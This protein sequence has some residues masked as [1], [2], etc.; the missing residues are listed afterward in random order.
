[1][2][3]NDA[4]L[5]SN[6]D[7]FR[8]DS[9]ANYHGLL[10][11]V[12]GSI[13]GVNLSANHTWAHCISDRV[14]VGIANPNQT[15]HRDRDRANCQSDRRHIFNLTSVA[16]APRFE[17]PTWRA[18]ASDWRLSVLYRVSSGTP[19][20]ITAGTD[21]ALT[22]LAGQ[23]ADQVSAD[24]YQDTSGRLGSQFLNRAAFAI[25]ALGTYGNLDRFTVRGFATWTLD[26]AL[27]RIFNLGTQRFELRAEA[28][29]LPNAARPNNPPTAL[30]NPNFGRVTTLQ[31]PRVMQFALK[32]VF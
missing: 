26:V 31:D 6:I 21:R 18:V 28:F 24:V 8:S 25:P 15:F 27:S 12:R 7:E 2:L 11:S 3:L 20:T 1:V 30:T 9:S 13:R 32:Y 29:N 22:G 10:T 16:T 4:S 5:F 23:T 14:N 19:L 17:N